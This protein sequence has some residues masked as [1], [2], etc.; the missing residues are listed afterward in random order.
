MTSLT[1]SSAL[2]LGL[3]VDQQAAAVERRVGAVDA[4]E[5][6]QAVDVGILEDGGGQ[7]LLPL[8]HGGVG[9]ALR[10][11]GNALDEAGVLDR[12]EALG[13]TR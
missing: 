9:D 5:G 1:S 2:V 8:R 13:M 12:E 3:E 10:R 7:R 4:D 11:L 6:G